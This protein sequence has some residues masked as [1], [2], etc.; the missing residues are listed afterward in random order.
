MGISVSNAKG[1]SI[2]RR[3][4][5][6]L[7]GEGIL[8]IPALALFD[9][10]TTMPLL[11]DRLTGSSLLVGLL[12]T[13]RF[14]GMWLPALPV[15]NFV[16]HRERKLPWLLYA[17]LARIPIGFL[18]AA[19]LFAHRI[20][21]ALLIALVFITHSLFWLGEGC[22]GLTWTD[23]VGK[24]VP[25]RQRGRFFG[26]MQAFGSLGA[27]C[28]GFLVTRVLESDALSFPANYGILFIL[29]FVLFMGSFASIALVKEPPGKVYKEAE[30]FAQFLRRLPEYLKREP[31][32]VRIV[33]KIFLIGLSGLALP[34][35]VVYAKE[36]L[37]L[38]VSAAGYFISAQTLGSVVGGLFWGYM[39]HSRGYRMV[40]GY[41]G[42][43]QALAPATALSAALLPF[44]SGRLTLML[45]A[46]FFLGI[47]ASGWS[48]GTNC[49]LE[50][51]PPQDLAVYTALSSTMQIPLFLAPFVGGFIVT[52]AGYG[53]VFILAAA[54][55]AL[56]QAG[57]LPTK[58]F[59]AS[60]ET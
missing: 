12:G 1:D 11:V 60:I 54:L 2:Q 58:S 5:W 53:V 39:G 42:I 44:T 17:C 7:L 24:C 14:A 40:I 23:I 50:T 30:P 56:A 32:F 34:F 49:I 28:L 20:P 51:V 9:P 29:S 43:A 37:G 6:A 52:T 47:G 48:V 38:P 16:K 59:P 57:S 3:N 31:V 8:F 41:V 45:L 36:I 15:A 21:T 13:L 10:A 55:P 33:A 22:A 18:G 4:F 26:L 46:Y 27:F 19:L 25:E 35:Y